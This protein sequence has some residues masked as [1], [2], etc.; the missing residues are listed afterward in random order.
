MKAPILHT[1]ALYSGDNGR[2]FC[3]AH[4]GQTAK[5]TGRDLS[6]QRVEEVSAIDVN[7]ARLHHGVEFACETCGFQP[8]LVVLASEKHA[9][10]VGAR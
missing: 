10:K 6:G 4:A 7:T 2:L 1:D 5:Y 9:R 8:R 3:G